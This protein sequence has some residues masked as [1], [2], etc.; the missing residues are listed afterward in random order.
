MRNTE[1]RD[2]GQYNDRKTQYVRKTRTGTHQVRRYNRPL[3]CITL[4][5]CT[6]KRS[7]HGTHRL[8]RS[9]E[10][11]TKAFGERFRLSNAQVRRFIIR[12]G[13]LRRPGPSPFFSSDEE[14]LL[15][16]T[17]SSMRR[18]VVGCPMTR[19]LECVPPTSQSCRQSGRPL[20][21]PNLTASCRPGVAG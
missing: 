8:L 12:G 19:S 9:V 1:S 16:S 17:L 15:A 5:S 21:G 11:T 14:D 18:S 4:S 13:A 20:H 2:A 7:P 3:N 6:I 10:L